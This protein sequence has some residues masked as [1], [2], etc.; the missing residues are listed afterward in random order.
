MGIHILDI[1]EGCSMAAGLAFQKKLIPFFG[2]GFTANCRSK[3]GRCPTSQALNE[4][5]CN[6][7]MKYNGCTRED[8]E[9]IFP[10]SRKLFDTVPHSE[11]RS[12]YLDYLTEIELEPYK[13]DFLNVVDWPRAYTSNVDNA[14]ESNGNFQALLPYYN[15]KNYVITRK[16]VYKLY[17]DAYTEA[18][19][20]DC[21]GIAFRNSYLPN[22]TAKKNRDFVESLI[23]DYSS[24]NFIFVGSSPKGK[25]HMEYIFECSKPSQDLQR[26]QVCNAVPTQEEEENLLAIGVEQIILVEDFDLFYT[27]FVDCYRKTAANRTSS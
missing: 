4:I 3:N 16:P 17:G 6:L 21:E 22:L 27:S 15:Y 24:Y 2:A 12:F 18:M 5:F 26:F 8:L 10:L 11:I 9:G 19:F 25:K 14:I 20:D 23:S 1:P 13:Y 7:I